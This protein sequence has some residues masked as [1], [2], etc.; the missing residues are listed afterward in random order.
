MNEDTKK[1]LWELGL[2]LQFLD[3]QATRIREAIRELTPQDIGRLS[4]RDLDELKDTIPCCMP[5]LRA[6][7]LREITDRA[8]GQK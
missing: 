5:Y 6:Q 1:A 7:V 8:T 2:V 3:T 4:D